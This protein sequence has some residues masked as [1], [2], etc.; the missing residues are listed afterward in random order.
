MSALTTVL[1]IL[2]VWV[3]VGALVSLPV[4]RML[5]SAGDRYDHDPRDRREPPALRDGPET[6]SGPQAAHTRAA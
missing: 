3:A 2:A 4:G 5:A 6:A 1:V